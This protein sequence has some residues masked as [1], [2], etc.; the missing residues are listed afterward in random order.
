MVRTK[1][2]AV[3]IPIALIAVASA[4]LLIHGNSTR[5]TTKHI[6]VVKPIISRGNFSFKVLKVEKVST[7]SRLVEAKLTNLGEDKEGVRVVLEAFCGKDKIN[8]NGKR[9]VVVWVGSMKKNKSVVKSLKISVGLFDALKIKNAGKL[10]LVL[11]VLWRK[12]GSV[13]EQIFTKSV[14]V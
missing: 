4:I 2:L 9:S 10:K 3:L 7:L 14:N 1:Y 13:Y 6:K 12:N 5:N 11:R 8:L